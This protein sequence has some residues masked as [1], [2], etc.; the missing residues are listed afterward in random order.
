MTSF[1]PSYSSFC[2]YAVDPKKALSREPKMAYV[3]QVFH[4][5]LSAFLLIA[6][7]GKQWNITPHFADE[8]TEAQGK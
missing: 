7:R 4:N 6:L 1:T 3:L 2:L 8:Q 5:L